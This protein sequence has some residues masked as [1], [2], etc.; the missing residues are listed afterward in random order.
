MPG[1]AVLDQNT[2]MAALHAALIVS[3]LMAV[4]G[5]V[6]S[7]PW[8]RAPLVDTTRHQVAES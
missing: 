2:F 3:G 6:T 7:L 5:A 8:L 1:T 4:A